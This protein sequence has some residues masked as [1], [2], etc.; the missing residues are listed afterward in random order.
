MCDKRG[1]I[2]EDVID[3]NNLGVLN[4]GSQAFIRGCSYPRVLDLTIGSQ[5]AFSDTVW[6]VDVETHGSDHR[7]AIS[8]IAYWYAISMRLA[9]S[10]ASGMRLVKSRVWNIL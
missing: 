2:L 9:K 1:K 6:H 10:H 8:K 7:Y 4:D 3:K 5:D